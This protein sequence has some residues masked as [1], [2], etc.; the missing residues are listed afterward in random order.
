ML[1][2]ISSAARMRLFCSSPLAHWSVLGWCQSKATHG[3]TI[4]KQKNRG[5]GRFTY[6]R[7]IMVYRTCQCR[8][9]QY[10]PVLA[11]APPLHP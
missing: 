8:K 1:A 4:S 7:I 2:R 9:C 5:R 3:T 6:S 10:I 11:V